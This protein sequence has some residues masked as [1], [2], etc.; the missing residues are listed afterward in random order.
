MDEGR[1]RDISHRHGIR[2]LVQFGSSVAGPVHARSDLDLGVL[3]ACPAPT[4]R[5]LGE[6]HVAL[7]SLVADRQVDV[8]ILNRADPRFRK[9]APSAAACWRGHRA[10]CTSSGCTRSGATRIT[11]AI[12]T[13]S[14]P[15][16][17]ADSR[18]P[19]AR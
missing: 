3:L 5:Q 9:K 19:A 18:G 2:L 8:A 17:W 15:M 14:A 7:Q 10:T 6:I 4:L 12:S 1:L 13:S 16:S 11:G